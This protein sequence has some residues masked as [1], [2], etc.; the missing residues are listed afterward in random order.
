MDTVIFGNP[1]AD[2]VLIQP[3]DQSDLEMIEEE[4]KIIKELTCKDF[5]L[6]AF[7]VSDWNRELTPWSAPAVFGKTDFGDGAGDTL[8]EI[9]DVCTDGRKTYYIGGYS[10]AGLFSLWAAYQTDIFKGVG[11][12]SPSVWYPGFDKYFLSHDIKADTVY[13]SLGDKEARTKNQVMARVEENIKHLN[14][15]LM[16]N[17]IHCHFE[18]NLGNHFK[19]SEIRTAKAFAYILNHQNK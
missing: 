8:K 14:D 7:K 1:E 11:A 10:L 3:V 16:N 19:D 17:N 15:N 4:I 9:L 18:S 2:I 6:I 13:L 12:A 5:K